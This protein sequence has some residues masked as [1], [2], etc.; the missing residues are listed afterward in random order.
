MKLAISEV[1]GLR[2]HQHECLECGEMPEDYHSNSACGHS[3]KESEGWIDEHGHSV[4]WYVSP[5]KKHSE[6]RN[7]MGKEPVKAS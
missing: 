7:G 2:V 1:C 5:C 3:R 4:I 6:R